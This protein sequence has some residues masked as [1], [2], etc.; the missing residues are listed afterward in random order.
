MKC[1]L[2]I[3]ILMKLGKKGLISFFFFKLNEIENLGSLIK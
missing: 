3:R 2:E 1:K